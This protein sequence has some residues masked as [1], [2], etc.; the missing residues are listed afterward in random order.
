MIGQQINFTLPSGKVT[1]TRISEEGFVP[2][3][4]GKISTWFE[5]QALCVEKLNTMPK[6]WQEIEKLKELV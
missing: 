2:K 5:F 1:L 4:V 6:S 3:T